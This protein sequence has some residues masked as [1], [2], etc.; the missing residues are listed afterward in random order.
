MDGVQMLIFQIA[1]WSSI[2]SLCWGHRRVFVTDCRSLSA[3]EGGTKSEATTCLRH[4]NAEHLLLFCFN[5]T[6]LFPMFVIRL[7]Y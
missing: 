2:A 4:S 5:P 3:T 1:A 6:Y 7:S